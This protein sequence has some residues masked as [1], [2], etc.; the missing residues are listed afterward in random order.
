MDK[1]LVAANNQPIHPQ[2]I[3]DMMNAS[4]DQEANKIILDIS[5]RNGNI[6]KN[7]ALNPILRTH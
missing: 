4:T 7:N 3:K 5:K 1:L 6:R 2:V